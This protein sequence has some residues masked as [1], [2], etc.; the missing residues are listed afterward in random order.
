MT[1]IQ[2]SI[3]DKDRAIILIGDRLVTVYETY[4]AEA[5]SQKLYG[6]KSFGIGFSGSLSDIICIKDQI[7]EK[8]NFNETIKLI[9]ENY[10]AENERREE[11]FLIRSTF[12]NKQEFKE[13]VIH[14]QGKI[15]IELVEWI[16]AQLEEIRLDCDALTIGFNEKN[17]PIII[18]I[19]E[20]GDFFNRTENYHCAIGMGEV[21]S[22]VFFDVNEYD[23]TCSLEEG[24]LFAFRAKKSAEAHIGV[25][26]ATDI[27]IIRQ[28]EE[29]ILILNE[30]KEMVELVEICDEER[31]K[32]QNLFNENAKEVE[33]ILK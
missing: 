24:L 25:G 31:N 17:E 8:P 12:L 23:P 26:N 20:F 18:W 32:I 16:Y 3:C 9:C 30:S 10:K 7:E 6:F 11:E 15:P 4:E 1:I 28:N 21:F 19:N 27:L 22:D 14:D 2:A 5:K 33:E 13:Y 29:P